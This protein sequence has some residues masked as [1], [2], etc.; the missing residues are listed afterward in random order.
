MKK[1]LAMMM[2]MAVI[3]LTP[4]T[5]QAATVSGTIGTI[6]KKSGYEVNKTGYVQKGVQLRELPS[7]KSDPIKNLSRNTKVK[8]R[9]YNDKWYIVNVDGKY[10][11]IKIDKISKKM[12][13]AKTYKAKYSLSYFRRAGVIHWNGWRWTYYSEK[14][15]PG[16]GLKIPGRHV[17][18]NGFVCDENNYICLASSRLSKGTV[19]DTPFGKQGKIY[20]SGC[21]SNTLDVYIH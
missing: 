15:L 7:S 17:D 13:G 10:G 20:D 16:H 21:A 18:G 14:V 5:G 12:A 3:F 19:V 9:K 4:L 6:V 11:F 1:I 2:A 8:Y